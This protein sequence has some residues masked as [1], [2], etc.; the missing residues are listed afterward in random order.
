MFDSIIHNKYIDKIIT[1][2]YAKMYYLTRFF[3]IIPIHMMYEI[4][5]ERDL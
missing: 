5:K 4:K 3:Q 2:E 1:N